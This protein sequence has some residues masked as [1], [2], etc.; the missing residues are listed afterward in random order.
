[1]F[2]ELTIT[3]MVG[4]LFTGA[5]AETYGFPTVLMMTTGLVLLASPIALMLKETSIRMQ[6][7]IA[8]A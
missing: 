3:G 6:V 4:M 7:A 1:V 8:E 2:Y 5:I